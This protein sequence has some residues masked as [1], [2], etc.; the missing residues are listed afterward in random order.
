MDSKAA[1]YVAAIAAGLAAAHTRAYR[2]LLRN[3]D[4]A[5][6]RYV[7]AVLV[8]QVEGYITDLEQLDP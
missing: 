6:S 4:E 8:P 2:R 3:H 5:C 1:T 7:A